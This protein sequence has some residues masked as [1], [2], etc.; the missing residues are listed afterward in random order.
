MSDPNPFAYLFLDPTTGTL[1]KH[2]ATLESHAAEFRKK[3][4]CQF[5]EIVPL[6]SSVLLAPNMDSQVLAWVSED[7]FSEAHPGLWMEAEIGVPYAG[8]VI[9]TGMQDENGRPTGYTIAPEQI[10]KTIFAY[11]AAIKLDP[12]LAKEKKALTDIVNEGVLTIRLRKHESIKI[13]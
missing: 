9:F 3:L 1:S 2:T 5:L 12:D 7:G 6:R 11:K 8:P 4:N 13:L 10:A